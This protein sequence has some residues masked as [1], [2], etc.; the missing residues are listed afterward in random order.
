M[1]FVIIYHLPVEHLARCCP[2]ISKVLMST[3]TCPLTISG[4]SSAK[5]NGLQIPNPLKT[6]IRYIL[7]IYSKSDFVYY[8]LPVRSLN[9]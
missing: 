3:L 6:T 1:G 4:H 8:I 5:P 2:T 7:L 9:F